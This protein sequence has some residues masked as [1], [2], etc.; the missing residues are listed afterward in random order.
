MNNLGKLTLEQLRDRIAAAETR[1]ALAAEE[2]KELEAELTDR[3]SGEVAQIMVQMGKSHGELTLSITNQQTG[4]VMKFKANI[5]KTVKWDS[6]RLQEIAGTM[7]WEKAEKLFD[8]KFSVQEK[9]YNA[10]FDEQLLAQINEARTV[11]YGEVAVK[12]VFDQE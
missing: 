1:K 10:I 4:E 5:S 12:P 6:K 11:K 7:D 2:L 3:L 9:T 8:I